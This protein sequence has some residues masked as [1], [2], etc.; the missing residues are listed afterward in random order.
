VKSLS[1]VPSKVGRAKTIPALKVSFNARVHFRVFN[2]N[3]SG[4]KAIVSCHL[5]KF[6]CK[7]FQG[8]QTF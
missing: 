4:L 2:L 7:M 1:V 8:K 5:K 6:D 3:Q